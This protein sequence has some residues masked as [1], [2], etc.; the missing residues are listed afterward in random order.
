MISSDI[1]STFFAG[2]LAMVCAF[3]P[4]TPSHAGAIASC[5]APFVFEGSAAN[6]VPIEYL[7]TSAETHEREGS[8]LG[9]IQETAQHLA[10]LMKLDS[11]HQP[12]YG[13]LGAVAHVF[14]QRRCTGDDV[15][16]GLIVGSDSPP[17]PPGQILL[18]LEGKI[19][20][21]GEEIFLQSRLRGFRRNMEF[22]DRRRPFT[23]YMIAESV[24]AALPNEGAALAAALPVIDVT[25]APRAITEAELD[26]IDESFV[27]ASAIHQAPSDE[28]PASSLRFGHDRPQAFSV[29]LVEGG[30]WIKVA[31]H[32]SGGPT[33]FIR[34]NP[35]VSEFL[36][37]KLPELDFVNGILGFFRVRQT[38]NA[39]PDDPVSF[40]P[41]PPG[42]A[43]HARASL[44]RFLDRETIGDDDA[45]ALAS[46]LIGVLDGQSGEWKAARDAFAAA[47]AT[48]P[49][50][51]EYRNLLGIADAQLCCSEGTEIA[52][53]DPAHAFVDAISIDPENP[54]ALRNLDAFLSLLAT[55][56]QS[57]EGIDASRLNERQGAVRKA[58]SGFEEQSR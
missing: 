17:I 49:Y 11:W 34:T 9:K 48:A 50:R 18:M 53:G 3:W 43:K 14:N 1:R 37:A 55:T 27:G 25:F 36:H 31:G 45:K 42:A 6:I 16:M 30:D 29:Q 52:S 5:D 35:E 2:C 12:T 13:S 7:A 39:G 33:G 44:Q 46:A 28:S 32:R 8:R 40:R 22:P 21:E 10:W 41:A 23:R 58:L 47:V 56:G 38:M 20:I 57:P 54:T 51:S 19:F 15:L 26:E 24:E 4:A